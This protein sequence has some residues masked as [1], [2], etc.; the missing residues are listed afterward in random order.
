MSKEKFPLNE[1]MNT[2]GGGA[3]AGIGVGPDGEP[4]VKPKHK[5]AVVLQQIFRRRAV[6]GLDRA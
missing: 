2:A 4:G 3:V 1:E 5:T 6:Q